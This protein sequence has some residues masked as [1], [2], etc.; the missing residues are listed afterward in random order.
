MTNIT[1]DGLPAKT[2]TISDAGIIHYREGGV[3]KK[4]TV[5]DFLIRI[6]EEYSTDINTFLG[7]A[8]KAAGRAALGIARRTAVNNSDYTILLTDKVVAQTGTMSAARTFSLPAA[9]TYPAGEELIVEDE[10]GTVT[11]TNII[12]IVRNGSDTID[13]LTLEVINE[14]YGLVRLISDGTSKWKKVNAGQA[15]ISKFGLR[16]LPTQIMH[17]NNVSDA[18]NDIDFTI[19]SF[20]FDD[21]TGEGYLT[22]AL[23]KR[24]DAAWA[25]GTN[26][27]GLDTGAKASASTYHLHAIWNPTTKTADI[28]YSLSATAPTMPSGYTKSARIGSVATDGSSNL[29]QTSFYFNVVTAKGQILIHQ[30]TDV[31]TTTTTVPYD[32]T[33]PQNTE[34]GAMMAVTITAKKT[35]NM[36]RAKHIGYYEASTPLRAIAAMFKGAAADAVVTGRSGNITSQGT[37]GP[38]VLEYQ[39][40][41]GT[42]SATTYSVRAGCESAGTL[43]FNGSTGGGRRFGGTSCGFLILTENEF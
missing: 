7:A 12:S 23:T 42:V 11:A 18:N 41:I 34:G 36:V 1:L 8:D 2:G 10:S 6:S 31:I 20:V 27:G 9:S 28:L 13:G 29:Y 40:I 4:M 5:A 37:A 21:G 15:T 39:D 24:L 17:K 35:T 26:Q 25:A 38:I 33:K 22:T 16:L 19:G 3:D 30:Y 14:P 32:D 43:T